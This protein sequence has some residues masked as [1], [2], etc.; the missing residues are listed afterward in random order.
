MAATQFTSTDQGLRPVELEGVHMHA[1]CAE[2]EGLNARI[3]AWH[4][5]Y[6][7]ADYAMN[8]ST[9]FAQDHEY[10]CPLCM[11]L[12]PQIVVDGEWI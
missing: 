11:E 8:A 5:E 12:F 2:A 3:A 4:G 9:D 1:K 7:F 6:S 10:M